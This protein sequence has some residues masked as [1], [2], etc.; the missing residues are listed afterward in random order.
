MPLVPQLVQHVLVNVVT[1]HD[2]HALREPLE[3]ILALHIPKH[4]PRLPRVVG[5]VA[6]VEPDP[7]RLVP[8]LHHRHRARQE[9]GHPARHRVVRVHE[10]QEGARERLAVGD[11]GRQLPLI[12]RVEPQLGLV[13]LDQPHKV[14]AHAPVRERD[15]L[16]GQVRERREGLHERV[17]V[18]SRDGDAKEVPR[19]HIRRPV[20]PSNVRISRRAEPPVGALR[21]PQPHLEQLGGRTDG[22]AHAGGVCGDERGVID[23]AEERSLQQLA[24]ANRALNPQQRLPRKHH[25]ALGEGEDLDLAAVEAGKVLKKALIGKGHLVLEVA[26]VSAG[27]LV[28]VDEG[29]NLA[30]P[31]EDA[32]A[33]PEGGRAEE[34]VKGSR[35]LVAPRLPVTVAHCDLVHVS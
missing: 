35:H 12:R 4:P 19:K 10:R 1:R 30:E 2:L 3:P 13:R 28:R 27:D 18:R 6:R 5:Q 20:K 16:P 21:A 25:A 33:A 7:D 15:A 24:D 26:D 17:G 8:Q 9:V 14:L 31:R 11:I 34:H 23:G 29:E 32:V 22:D